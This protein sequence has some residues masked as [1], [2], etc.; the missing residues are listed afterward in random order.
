M[1][2]RAP[3]FRGERIQ[4]PVFCISRSKGGRRASSG[5]SIKEVR[6]STRIFAARLTTSLSRFLAD[7]FFRPEKRVPAGQLEPVHVNVLLL[8]Y[9][10]HYSPISRRLTLISIYSSIKS[11][12]AGRSRARCTAVTVIIDGYSSVAQLINIK[13]HNIPGCFTVY[14]QIQHL[15]E[16]AIIQ[17]PVPAD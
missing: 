12:P 8:I 14:C 9:V 3:F 10:V 1:A 4:C 16:V 15:I 5:L 2:D 6:L 11:S 17:G 7:H 13:I